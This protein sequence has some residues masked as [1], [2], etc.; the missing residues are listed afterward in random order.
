MNLTEYI[1]DYSIAILSLL[2][3][4]SALAKRL[5][6]LSIDMLYLFFRTERYMGKNEVCAE[7]QKQLRIVF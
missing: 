3:K 4:R 7:V 5:L 2:E 6:Y 1:D